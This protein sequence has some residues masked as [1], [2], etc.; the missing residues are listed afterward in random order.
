MLPETQYL[1]LKWFESKVP[2]PY[3]NLK[4][5]KI[6]RGLRWRFVTKVRKLSFVAEENPNEMMWWFLHESKIIDA[7]LK[8]LAELP[9][10][11]KTIEDRFLNLITKIVLE[12]T[13]EKEE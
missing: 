11:L 10:D 4:A 2:N 7:A 5:E 9:S 3:V 13:D 1:F 6:S 8:D 12:L